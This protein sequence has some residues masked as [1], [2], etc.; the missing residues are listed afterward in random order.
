M[1]DIKISSNLKEVLSNVE[2]TVNE[3]YKNQIEYV[4][5][6]A[7][8]INTS[9]Q[10]SLELNTVSTQGIKTFFENIRKW[11]E[12]QKEFWLE[13]A[14]MG[15]YFNWETPIQSSNEAVSQG[16]DNLDQFMVTHLNHDWKKLTNTIVQFCP[17]RI[18]VLQEAFALHQEGR[19]MA[20]IPLFLSQ[21]DG[22][23]AQYLGVFLFSEHDKRSD[24]IGAIL[25]ES[26]DVFLNL[27]LE[28]LTKK[29]QYGEGIGKNSQKHKEISPNRN[30]I[31]HGS[32]KHLDYGTKLN[33]LKCF[34]LLAFVVFALVESSEDKTS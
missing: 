29:N 18:L 3:L 9:L 24:K 22:I 20:S 30:G 25:A 7:N 13:A 11:P 6:F 23:C 16:K 12:W 27:L 15:W 4:N 21:I 8:A 33:S 1:S 19:Y 32:R 34:S 14:S 28:P 26:E 5:S 10:K 17:E 2:E 31:L